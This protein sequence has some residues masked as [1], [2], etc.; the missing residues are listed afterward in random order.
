LTFV[1]TS[2]DRHIIEFE[3]DDFAVARGK[4]RTT[5]S[6]AIEGTNIRSRDIPVEVWN[7]D[8][9]LLTPRHLEI[10]LGK[11]KQIV[12]EVTNDDGTRAT[13]VLLN[14]KHDADDP[15]IVRI[16]PAGWVTGNRRGR[17]NV[18]AGAGNPEAEGV[19]ARIPAEVLVV[20]NPD[21]V[22]RG[23]GFP[24]LL[25]TGRDPD[26]E[27]GE[28][29]EGDPEQPA[30]WQEVSDFRNN[31]WWLNLENPAAFFHFSHF[32]ERPELW[33]SFHA[34]KVVDMVQQVHMQS[35][36][37][38]KEPDERPDYWASH[39]ATLE[40]IEVQLAQIMWEQLSTYVQTGEGLD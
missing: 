12:A 1:W 24:Q 13:N 16:N 32:H 10:P 9:V 27:T 37:T 35:E 18:L 14:W 3:N 34:Q 22:Q 21:E 40:R 5:I 8:H 17:T 31:V 7:V 23:S 36:Y 2:K 6:I 29:R 30:L 19:W 20:E 38:Q 25:L 28:V 4:G 26:P 11:R 39:K 33:R 15:L